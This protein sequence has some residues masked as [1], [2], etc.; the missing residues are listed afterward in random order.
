MNRKLLTLVNNERK[1]ARVLSK[2]A[3]SGCYG[4]DVCTLIDN[5]EDCGM[6]YCTKDYS[7]CG[8]YYDLCTYD[9]GANCTGEGQDYCD[10]DWA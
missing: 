8:P 7:G 6:D 9:Y 3:F 10:I 1:S 2:K 5:S 4:S